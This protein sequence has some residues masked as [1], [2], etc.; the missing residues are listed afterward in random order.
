MRGI[1]RGRVLWVSSWVFGQKCLRKTQYDGNDDATDIEDPVAFK[2]K[3]KRYTS[4]TRTWAR[5]RTSTSTTRTP[6]RTR[7]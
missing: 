1:S 7:T 6:A 3:V 4:E 2:S 5:T